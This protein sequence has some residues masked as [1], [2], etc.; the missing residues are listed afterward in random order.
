MSSKYFNFNR[1]IFW[2]EVSTVYYTYAS[3]IDLFIV[4]LVPRPV[5]SFIEPA[6]PLDSSNLIFSSQ[7]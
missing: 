1:N 3:N 4:L 7:F 5:I 2:F 6:H